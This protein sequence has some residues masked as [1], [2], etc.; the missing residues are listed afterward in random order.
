[1]ADQANLRKL[2]EALEA[3]LGMLKGA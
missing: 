1:L 3:L 2:K